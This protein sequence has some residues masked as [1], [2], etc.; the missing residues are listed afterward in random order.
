[1]NKIIKITVLLLVTF[2]F[3]SIPALYYILKQEHENDIVDAYLTQH[4]LVNLPLT[5]ETALKVSEQVRVDFNVKEKTFKSLD[6]NNRPFLRE[7]TGYLLQ[8]KEGL[9]GEGT[10]VMVALL[11][12]MGFDS[13]RVTLYNKHL[14]S[15]HTLISLKLNGQESLIDSIN[16]APEL[17]QFLKENEIGSKDFNLMHYS[18]SLSD[19]RKFERKSNEKRS[20]Y[21]KY[22]FNKY[23]VYSYEATPYT[24]VLTKLGINVRIFNFQR[25]VA[26]VSSMAEQPLMMMYHVLFLCAFILSLIMLKMYSFRKFA[27]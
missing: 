23:R 17:T 25:P 14:E 9:C 12:R 3:L 10:R 16:A 21:H 11:N 6:M 15:T 7:S 26:Y 27:F 8:H 20:E 19:R 22:F 5:R 1:M 2:S 24:K 4:G 18:D 13:T